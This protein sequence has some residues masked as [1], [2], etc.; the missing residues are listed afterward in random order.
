MPYRLRSTRTIRRL[1]V[2]AGAALLLAACAAT[3]VANAPSTPAAAGKVPELRPGVPA[4]YLAADAIPDSLAW[5][6][7]RRRRARRRWRRTTR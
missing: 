2:V 4:G 6:P 1:A 3:P 5:C 7:R